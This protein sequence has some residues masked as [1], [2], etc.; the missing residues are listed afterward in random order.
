MTKPQRIYISGPMTG[1]PDFN[2]PA[3]HGVAAALRGAGF[4]VCN[5]AENGIPDWAPWTAHMRADIVGLMA[6]QGLCYLPS[7]ADSRGAKIEINLATELEITVAPLEFWLE[8]AQQHHA[9]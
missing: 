6:C 2:K 7:W 8:H 1:L 5:P 4:D 3:F 9:K